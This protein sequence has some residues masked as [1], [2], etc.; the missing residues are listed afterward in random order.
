M[1]VV[2][3][4]G[5]EEMEKKGI[6]SDRTLGTLIEEIQEQFVRLG[7]SRRS[8]RRFDQTWRK[9][10]RFAASRDADVMSAELADAF[11][12]HCMV[13][14][15]APGAPAASGQRHLLMAMRI[16]LEFDLHGCFQRRRS[17]SYP[18]L[19]DE[20]SRVM[21]EYERFC[22]EALRLS[23]VTMR[24]RGRCVSRFLMYL[25]SRGTPD[26]GTITIGTV[27]GFVGSQCHLMPRT[28]A[29][30]ASNLRSFLRFL[31]MKGLV[32]AALVNR[33]PRIRIQHDA[34]IPDVWRAEHV[35]SLLATVDRGSPLG[36]RDYAILLLAARLGL[37]VGDIRDL[38]LED[39]RWDEARIERLQ[40]K[41]GTPV[42]LPLTEEIGQALIA[43]LQDGRPPSTRREVFLRHLAPFGPFERTNSL[44]YIIDK[45][46]RLAGIKLPRAAR[47]GLHSLR[48]TVATR[49][50]EAGVPL[51]AISGVMGHVSSEST[52]IYTKVDLAALR[53]AALEIEEVQ[54]A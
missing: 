26:V 46:R 12:E 16:L 25:A 19:P 13:G 30:L 51:E 21:G 23:P 3:E 52:R 20:L 4:E 28:L 34:R 8:R 36:R 15:T 7:Y 9:L 1:V 24:G 43:Y 37:R 27:S 32:P 22:V 11:L 33:V 18:R 41:T 53:S 54:H 31:S 47:R 50:L 45:Y 44:H 38:R 42:V 40:A 14:S 29:L 2:P 39:L 6:G 17:G 49:L 48:H 5:D 10:A 35:A